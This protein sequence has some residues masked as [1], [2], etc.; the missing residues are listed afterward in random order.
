MQRLTAFVSSL[1]IYFCLTKHYIRM[2]VMMALGVG[3]HPLGI[4]VIVP[5]MIYSW[6][7]EGR[8]P[9]FAL[10]IMGIAACGFIFRLRDVFTEPAT[11]NL[12]FLQNPYQNLLHS[13]GGYFGNSVIPIGPTLQRIWEDFVVF[14]SSLWAFIIAAVVFV[15]RRENV[16]LWIIFGLAVFFP[17]ASIYPQWIKYMWLPMLPL[18]ILVGLGLDKIRVKYFAIPAIAACICFMT[19]NV[20][21][22]SPGKTIDVQPTTARQFYDSLDTIPD[23]AIVVGHTWGHPDLVI[24]YYSVNTHDRFDY[25]NFN[26]VANSPT[27]ESGYIKYQENKGI[28]MPVIRTYKEN[29]ITKVDTTVDEFSKELQQLNSGREVLV[30]YVK[31][32]EI[33]MAFALIPASDYYPGINDLPSSKVQFSG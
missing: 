28:V 21:Y 17:F 33:P 24:L 32:S 2:A 19:M 25:I 23:D 6:W 15:K 3:L 4:W 13:A 10:M 9:R 5:C 12:F 8:K 1:V 26:A 18:S 29:G 16:L 22:Y 27:E 30:T 7:I 31:D 11:S 20:A 14:G